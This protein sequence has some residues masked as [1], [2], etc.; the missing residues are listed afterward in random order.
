M[1]YIFIDRTWRKVDSITYRQFEGPKAH[2][3]SY[4]YNP[5]WVTGFKTIETIQ[6][7]GTYGKCFWIRVKFTCGTI[8]EVYFKRLEQSVE[9]ILETVK[10]MIPMQFTSKANWDA[11]KAMEIDLPS[12]Y[13]SLKAYSIR[14]RNALDALIAENERLLKLNESET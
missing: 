13:E 2:D 9:Q 3:N 11:K 7:T 8:H 12:D 1:L 5:I 4:Q 14:I 10:M 6:H